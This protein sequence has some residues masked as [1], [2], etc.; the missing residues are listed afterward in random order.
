MSW[1]ELI[2]KF[3]PAKEWIIHNQR[4]DGSIQWDKKG[5]V[6]PWD[7][8]EC[9]IALAIF[10]EWDAFDK[11]VNWFFNELNDDG[12]I[13]AEYKNSKAS[14]PYYESH[15][16]PYI[17]LPLLQKLLIDNDADYFYKRI[18][19]LN[20]IFNGLS[21]FINAQGY[22]SW[23][24][25]SSGYSDNSLITATS[26]IKISL[27]AIEIILS[28]LLKTKQRHIQKTKNLSDIVK[29]VKQ[30]SIDHLYNEPIHFNKQFNRDGIDRSRFSMDFYYPYIADLVRKSSNSLEAFELDLKKFYV[31]TIGIKCVEEEPWVTFA[32]SAECII[33]IHNFYDKT[34]ARAI[35]DQIL[36]Y[37]SSDGIFSTGY[38]YKIDEYWPDEK[39][40][41]TNAAVI[42]AAHLLYSDSGINAF[43]ALS[44]FH[45]SN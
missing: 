23:A 24:K 29:K 35:F 8:C 37:V 12:L 34:K 25:D 21:K 4:T 30:D 18:D 38:Q 10:E 45:Q 44:K 11:G 22:F 15:H 43:K 5:K 42:I 14:K 13:F 2:E 41:W 33:A 17:A 26:S 27:D 36:K 20:K 40:T 1:I 19:G 39:S 3:Q 28:V 16:A 6:D 9:L 31:D 32:E 7:H